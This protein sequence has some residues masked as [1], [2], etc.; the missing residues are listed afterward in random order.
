M[1]SIKKVEKF[2]WNKEI[3]QDFIELKKVFTKGGIQT[4]LDFG[5]GNLFIL[6]MD[7]NREHCGSVIPGAVRTREIPRMLGTEV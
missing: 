3:E 7:W 6:T 4:F 1:N 2:M 5:V